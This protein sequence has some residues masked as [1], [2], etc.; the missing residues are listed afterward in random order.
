[1]CEGGE[2]A[3]WRAADSVLVCVSEE[4]RAYGT[5]RGGDTCAKRWQRGLVRQRLVPS[6]RKRRRRRNVPMARMHA[7]RECDW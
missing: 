4:R 7:P 2:R 3:Q 1:L 6:R 5:A